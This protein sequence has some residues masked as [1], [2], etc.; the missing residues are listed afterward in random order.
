[1]HRA[2]LVVHDSCPA[3]GSYQ[4]VHNAILM[5]AMSK[6]FGRLRTKF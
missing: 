4:A 3:N 6:D 5:S 2:K 1:M